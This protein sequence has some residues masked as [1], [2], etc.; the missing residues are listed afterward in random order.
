MIRGISEDIL[1]RVYDFSEMTNEELRCKFFQKLQ[2]CIDLC[3][4]SA[5]ILKWIKDEGLEKEVTDLLTLWKEDGTLESLI[6]IDLLNTIKTELS[7]KID[8]K[9]DTETF[10]NTVTTINEQLDNTVTTINEQLEQIVHENNLNNIPNT[11]KKIR[12]GLPIKILIIGDSL[13]EPAGT[14][15]KWTQMLFDSSYKNFGYNLKENFNIN[16]SVENIAVGGQ[17]IKLLL[18]QFAL[19][20]EVILKGSYYNQVIMGDYKS[21]PPR[22]SENYDLIIC[23]IGANGGNERVAY[24]ENLIKTIRNMGIE[25]ILT[26]SNPNT[27]TSSDSDYLE[28]EYLKLSKMYDFEIANTNKYFKESGKNIS[29]LL[30]DTI[31]SNE[32]GH[33]LY[34]KCFYD[35]FNK[36]LNSKNYNKNGMYNNNRVC[37]Y[38]SNEPFTNNMPFGFEIQYP[39]KHNGSEI[40][41]TNN[42]KCNP[43]YHRYFN[44]NNFKFIHLSV[45]QYADFYH[46][47]AYGF[48]IIYF[49][50]SQCNGKVQV[51]VQNG[52]QNLG[53]PIIIGNGVPYWRGHVI[54][55][56][57]PGFYYGYE[58]CN[59]TIRLE[60]I[61]G[62]VNIQGVLWLVPFDKY[63]L[64]YKK[65]G[66]WFEANPWEIFETVNTNTDGDKIEIDVNLLNNEYLSINFIE[67][68]AG[69]KIDV[70]LDGI[71][72]KTIN[73]YNSNS[74]E[75]FIKNLKLEPSIG[76]HKIQLILNGADSSA[77]QFDKSQNKNR[78]MLSDVRIVSGINKI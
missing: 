61:E 26:T 70:Y 78:F 15:I 68:N 58:K 27:S 37:N 67:N 29:D 48:D 13:A 21:T 20:R 19:E 74:T 16:S 7:N 43:F 34:A 1:R 76:K 28:I 54:D 24:L 5:D 46:D 4:N 11:T 2:E 63:I 65:I 31:H 45:G 18:S 44:D 73:T 53:E 56:I 50:N 17:T 23:S 41:D 3:N 49:E 71:F 75:Y 12:C 64:D 6:N 33:K 30:S 59:S 40:T 32:E 8:K 22:L 51:K 62:E 52:N 10:N 14:G 72:N 35:I 47:S 42:A 60:C 25:L 77:I 38:L 36:C 66:T 9:V 55:G 57:S 39:L 69:G